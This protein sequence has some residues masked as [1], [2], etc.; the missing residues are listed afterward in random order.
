MRKQ[1]VLSIAVSLSISENEN[2]GAVYSLPG[3][4]VWIATKNGN[5][6]TCEERQAFMSKLSKMKH[7]RWYATDVLY[8]DRKIIIGRSY[9]D[10]YPF[11]VFQSKNDITLIEGVILN[12]PQRRIEKELQ[13]ISPNESSTIQLSAKVKRFLSNTDGEFLAVKY[14]KRTGRCLIFNDALGRLPFYYLVLSNESLDIIVMSREVNFLIPFLKRSKQT[15]FDK[16]ALAEYLLFGYF[17]GYKTLWKDIERLPPATVLLIDTKSKEFYLRKVL[18]WKLDPEYEEKDL[19]HEAKELVNLFIN[20]LKHTTQAFSND[21]SQIVSLSGGLDSRATLA[22]LLEAG[23]IPI[24]CSFPS[25]ENS[26]AREIACKLNVKH[27]I[28]QSSFEMTHEDYSRI[29]G[30]G[31]ICVGFRSRVSYLYDI[32]EK[33][34]GKAI[35]YTGDGGD[36]TLGP[37]G[38]KFNILNIEKLLEYIIETDHIFSLDEISSI[39]NINIDDFREHLK[40][41]LIAYPEKTLEGKLSHFKVF[42]RGF[43]WLFPG[44]DRWRSFLWSTTPFYSVPFFKAAMNISQRA[45][46]HY[47]LYKHFLLNLNPVL[48]Q[49]QYYDRL[50]PLSTP[51]WLLKLY[52][53]VF[54]WLKMHF[55]RPGAINPIDLI[56]G[57]R[58]KTAQKEAR[59]IK[60]LALNHLGR[61][62]VYNFWNQ[63]KV[64]ELI[65]VETNQTKL[66][67]LATL[68][69]YASLVKSPDELGT[70]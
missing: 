37:L 15:D 22:G 55:Y 68:V 21:Y 41:H 26:I 33:I 67:Y 17:L 30:L 46:K 65:R 3:L 70:T 39:L 36:K 4:H 56:R 42:E 6:T 29:F 1:S 50:I 69:L 47:I 58:T 13:E 5:S 63:S 51:S 48:S 31:G 57:W 7:F 11:T 24:A 20:S 54:D 10:G 18:Q 38:F 32:K 8:S 40:N 64:S 44:E 35:L 60:T 49:I 62:S 43:N 14:D 45:K 59:N 34:G 66:T 19:E 12:K 27:Q 16:V 23:A 9:Y 53:S 2:L 25:G 28:V 61:K 52:L